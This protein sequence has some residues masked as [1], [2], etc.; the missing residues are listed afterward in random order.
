MVGVTQT[1]LSANTLPEDDDVFFVDVDFTG[2]DDVM[3]ETVADIKEDIIPEQKW[4]F[5]VDSLIVC[6]WLL[7]WFLPL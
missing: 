2:L 6:D 7:F 1:F 5:S 3:A 4:A